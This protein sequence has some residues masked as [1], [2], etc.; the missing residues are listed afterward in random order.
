MRTNSDQLQ[1]AVLMLSYEIKEIKQLLIANQGNQPEKHSVFLTISD[2]AIFLNL[3]VPTIYSKVSRGELPVMKRGKRL[4]FSR[5][6]LMQYIK[7]GKKK[8]TSEVEAEANAYLSN[9]KSAA[10]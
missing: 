7:E 8:S 2:A 6:D 9:K 1:R 3:T 10:L 5:E 4:Y